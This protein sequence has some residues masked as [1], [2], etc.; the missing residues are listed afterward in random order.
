MHFFDNKKR[1]ARVLSVDEQT[2]EE[3]ERIEVEG[4]N[5]IIDF[6][7]SL[8][9]D[10]LGQLEKNARRMMQ[11]RYGDNL[12]FDDVAKRFKKSSAALRVKVCRIRR[13]LRNC[14]VTKMRGAEA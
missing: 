4:H 14:V 6:R 9:V 12:P 2:L 13:W 7:K 5:D 10:C 3:I 8:L 1:D 11:M